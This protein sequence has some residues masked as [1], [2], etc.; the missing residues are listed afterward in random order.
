MCLLTY[1]PAG[2]LP[3]LDAL[4][5]GTDY[6]P[7]GHG[8]AIVVPDATRR[9]GGRLLVGK[10][11]DAELVLTR[12]DRDR[13]AHPDGPALFHSRLRTH[14]LV[15][16][17]NCHPFRLAGDPRT[18]M[19]HYVPRNIVREHGPGVASDREGMAVVHG[20]FP[21]RELPGVEQGR[22]VRVRLSCGEERG[23]DGLAV[24]ALLD[25]EPVIGGDGVAV[26]VLVVGGAVA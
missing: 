15:D 1:F 13:R 3:D 2:Q 6:N 14:G 17:A 7:D 5:A 10:G 25:D 23:E 22:P 20:P 4:K 18:V 11:L 21:V 8:Y 26:S 12:F 9:D 24:Q 16:E 19:A